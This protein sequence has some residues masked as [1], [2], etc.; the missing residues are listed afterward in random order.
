MIA[1]RLQTI[2]T[3]Q[4]LLYIDNPKKILAAEKGTAEY[5][6]IM[7]QLKTDTYKHQNDIGLETARKLWEIEHS[8]ANSEIPEE[9]D[10]GP[11]EAVETALNKN[12]TLEKVL[13]LT[14]LD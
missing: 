6:N 3:A 14:K 11:N 13:S 8:D 10:F 5:D 9:R 4:N 12:S 7:D 2:A 1:H